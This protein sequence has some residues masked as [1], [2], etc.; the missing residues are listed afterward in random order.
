MQ[1]HQLQR[2]QQELARFEVVQTGDDG[3]ERSAATNAAQRH[4]D[5]V[6]VIM[7]VERRALLLKHSTGTG[8]DTNKRQSMNRK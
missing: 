2:G 7:D 8:S 4:H 5:P 3:G 1:T 6:S